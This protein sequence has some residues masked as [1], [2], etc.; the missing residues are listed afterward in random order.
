[1]FATPLNSTSRLE[2]YGSIYVGN[3]DQEA[4]VPAAYRLPSE[5]FEWKC[6]IHGRIEEKSHCFHV[7]VPSPFV[8]KESQNNVVPIEIYGS[9]SS[10]NRAVIV[11][12]T[13]SGDLNLS[14]T[15]CHG[16]ADRGL[17]AALITLP[18]F[19]SR[20][21]RGSSCR[22]IH[23]D[24][25]QTLPGM[26]QAVLDVRRT[27][28]WLLSDCQTICRVETVGLFGV[29]LGGIIAALTASF[30]ARI[31]TAYLALAGG[32]LSLLGWDAPQLRR[33]RDVW[34]KHGLPPEKYF[35]V[36]A[37]FDPVT[38][39]SRLSHKRVHLFAATDDESVPPQAAVALADA[40][41]KC[42]IEWFSGGHYN[43]INSL[44]GST[45]KIAGFF[46]G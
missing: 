35:E 3:S 19:G 32:G 12:H 46:L 31:D 11:L 20:K 34:E 39:G 42:E 8:S 30:E 14:R 7:E 13:L 22:M 43:A 10:T 4:E 27:V 24:P 33:P 5:S 9:Q 28:D 2:H 17:T 18:Y 1:V 6:R 16:F 41:G 23:R 15:F 21:T 29:S 36:A 38:Y 37:Q 25:R 45:D 44:S 26:R 40:I